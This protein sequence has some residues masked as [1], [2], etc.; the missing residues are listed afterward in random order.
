M[1]NQE[2]PTIAH[3]V[4]SWLRQGYPAGVPRNDT[5]ALF[6]V[7][8]RELNEADLDELANLLIAEG[9]ENGLHPKPVTRE[10]I[11]K[12]ITHVHNQPP[13]DA[14]IERIQE[15]LKAEGFLTQS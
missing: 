3:R 14:D 13:E 7:L 15:K 8:E 2:H 12:L 6:Y 10:K 5:F 4:L 9:A 11:A 1:S